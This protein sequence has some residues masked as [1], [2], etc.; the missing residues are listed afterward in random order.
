MPRRRGD[1]CAM[2]AQGEQLE[3]LQRLRENG[4]DWDAAARE[5]GSLEQGFWAVWNGPGGTAAPGMSR[6][7]LRPPLKGTL[8]L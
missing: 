4:V 2:A 3:I 6:H 8:A 1:I 7:V 5:L